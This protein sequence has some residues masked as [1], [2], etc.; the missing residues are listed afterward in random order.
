MVAKLFYRNTQYNMLN[1]IHYKISNPRLIRNSVILIINIIYRSR[2]AH[3]HIQMY[4]HTHT[5]ACCVYKSPRTKAMKVC[6]NRKPKSCK[7]DDLTWF[8]ASFHR[9]TLLRFIFI[10]FFFIFIII[11]FIISFRHR[12]HWIY[13]T[14]M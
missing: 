14:I 11:R 4:T 5:L 7:C 6:I 13:I 3:T 9:V 10:H 1:L 8:N 12:Y 2:N